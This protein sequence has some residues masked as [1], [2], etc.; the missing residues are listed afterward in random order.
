MGSGYVEEHLPSEKALSSRETERESG[1]GGGEEEERGRERARTKDRYTYTH[2][3][4]GGQSSQILNTFYTYQK[5]EDT[6]QV[7]ILKA[8]ETCGQKGPE[9]LLEPVT[10]G[11]TKQWLTNPCTHTH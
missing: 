2:T 5:T 8:R 1:E 3:G 4:A 9:I 7:V 6:G 10:Y 11:D